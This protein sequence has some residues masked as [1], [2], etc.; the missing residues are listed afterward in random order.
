MARVFISHASDDQE[1]ADEVHR[2]LVAEDHEVFLD[3][4]LRDGLVVGEEWEQRLLERLRWA[5]A[6]VC[7]V[8]S[9]FLRSEWCSCEVGYARSRGS[10]LLPVRAEGGSPPGEVRPPS[11]ATSTAFTRWPSAPTGKGILAGHTKIVAGVAFSPDGRT[12][13]TGS[14]DNTARLWETDVERVV[15]RI[16]SITPAITRDEWNQYLTGLPYQPPC[17]RGR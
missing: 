12:L 1:L 17:Q 9:A 2:W 11:P 5:D 4:D 8:T 13:A 15:D 7:V 16:C 3:R 6:V 10:R 14:G